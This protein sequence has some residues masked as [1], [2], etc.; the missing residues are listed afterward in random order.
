MSG[1]CQ[2]TL[3]D[4]QNSPFFPQS[5]CIPL[6]P[7][8]RYLSLVSRMNLSRQD[9]SPSFRDLKQVPPETIY[10]STMTLLQVTSLIRL[11]SKL[12][13]IAWP[14]GP[15]LIRLPNDHLFC[16]FAKRLQNLR[17]KAPHDHCFFA[18]SAKSR[19]LKLQYQR[20][21]HVAAAFV[22]IT[23]GQFHSSPIPHHV[24]SSENFYHF[25]VNL[26]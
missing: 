5:T 24:S 8:T 19:L 3:G 2:I 11:P 14:L 20:G 17:Q 25:K 22:L 18:V 23:Q 21:N 4:S 10:S 9:L 7:I 26:D 13:A 16:L 15:L 12:N 6:L 1:V